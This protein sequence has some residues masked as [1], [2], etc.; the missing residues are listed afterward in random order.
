MKVI[1]T[2]LI[3]LAVSERPLLL[4]TSRSAGYIRMDD[5]KRGFGLHVSAPSSASFQVPLSD[6]LNEVI[7]QFDITNIQLTYPGLTFDSAV[8][9]HRIGLFRFGRPDDRR[10]YFS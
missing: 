2:I 8:A 7:P 10:L 6:V 3:A 4:G 9:Q 5:C 1:K